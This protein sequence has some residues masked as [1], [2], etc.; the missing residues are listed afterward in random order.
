M[1]SFRILPIMLVAM[2]FFSSCV[3][4]GTENVSVATGENNVTIV[5]SF[6]PMYIFTKNIAKDIE[7]V[8]VVNMAEPQAGC[9]HDY[10]L[11]PADLKKVEKADIM[12]INGAGMETFIEKI[13]KERPQ[14]K[15]VE[16]SRGLELIKED[17]H[18]HEDE[19]GDKDVHEED[20]EQK[21]FEHE[22]HD[23]SVNPHVWVSISGAIDEVKNIGNQLA[24][25][26]P[27]NAEKYLSNTNEYVKK[28]EVQK[29]KMNNALKG[30]ENRNIVT[31][32]K[33]FPYFAKEF[34]LN[35]VEVIET[36]EGS[37][38][39]AGELADKIKS[40]KEA[41]V[42]A[43]FTEPQVSNN[44]ASTVS[45]ETG[46]LVYEIDTVVSGPEEPEL[47]AYEKAMDEN[48]KILLEALK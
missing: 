6:Y 42:K 12:V 5:T 40:I 13:I 3:S 21:N 15:V 22:G 20:S 48:L 28:L 36:E 43:L 11:N 41:N 14:L 33:A 9:L 8:K 18:H 37:A 25:A 32:H 2:L 1:K 19:H 26:D 46:I 7:G 4:N 16:A 29:E 35:I 30:I 47:D 34:E 23:H 45:K 38:P 39:S 24:N 10:N 17:S 44:L 27:N 31:F